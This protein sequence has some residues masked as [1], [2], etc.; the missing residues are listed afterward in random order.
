MTHYASSVISVAPS[1]E[2]SRRLFVVSKRGL[3]MQAIPPVADTILRCLSVPHIS[4]RISLKPLPGFDIGGITSS[5]TPANAS[6]IEDSRNTARNLAPPGR[7]MQEM[8]DVIMQN[9][10][11]TKMTRIIFLSDVLTVG[12]KKLIL[13]CFQ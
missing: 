4:A 6:R 13:G 2:V 11:M 12:R 3:Q 5:L 8:N 9:W 10:S 7:K 1:K